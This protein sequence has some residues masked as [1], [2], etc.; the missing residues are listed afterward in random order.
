MSLKTERVLEWAAKKFP[1][2]KVSSDTIQAYA[3]ELKEL[4]PA[5]L[6]LAMKDLMGKGDFWPSLKGI[7]NAERH[8]SAVD[9]DAKIFRTAEL[10][11]I[12]LNDELRGGV[13]GDPKD[14]TVLDLYRAKRKKIMDAAGITEEQLENAPVSGVPGTM[15]WDQLRYRRRARGDEGT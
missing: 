13:Y 10:A 1:A 7:L 8:L 2:S 12:Q 5:R 14:G 6:E 4:D 9:T 15:T 11:L 3:E